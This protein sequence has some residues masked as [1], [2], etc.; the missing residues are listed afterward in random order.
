LDFEQNLLL[1]KKK[2]ISSISSSLEVKSYEEFEELN[3]LEIYFGI[4]EEPILYTYRL[5]NKI[6]CRN[7]F[8]EI[9]NDSIQILDNFKISY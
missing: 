1:K 5:S 4:D 6:K 3:N 8:E 2:R 7:A 9:V